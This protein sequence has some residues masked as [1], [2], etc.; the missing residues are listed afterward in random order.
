MRFSDGEEFSTLNARIRLVAEDLWKKKAAVVREVQRNGRWT[1]LKD[2][3][4]LEAV[5]APAPVEPPD[6]KDIPF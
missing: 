2:I 3:K 4:P 6:E 1:N 5:T